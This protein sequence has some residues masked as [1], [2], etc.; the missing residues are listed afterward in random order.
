MFIFIW[1]FPTDI[2]LYIH[3][4]YLFQTLKGKLYEGKNFVFSIAWSLRSY[5]LPGRK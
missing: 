5:N 2:W 4:F 1:T 3:V